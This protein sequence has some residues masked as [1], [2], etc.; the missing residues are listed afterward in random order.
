MQH[1][2][3]LT[4]RRMLKQATA[5]CVMSSLAS[6]TLAEDNLLSAPSARYAGQF[7]IG[8][9]R[10]INRLGYGALKITGEFVWGE[11]ERRKEA[12]EIIRALRQLDVNFVDTADAYG[13]FISEN[14]IAEAV[15]PY[16]DFDGGSL[17]VATK[18]G[19]V[20][21]NPETDPWVEIGHPAYLEQCVRM[22]LRRLKR[23]QLDLWQL[24]RIDPN[25][26]E[27]AQYRAI[28][29]FLEL[30]LIKYA[31]L[32]EVNVE[33]IERARKFFPVATVQNRYNLTYRKSEDV[34][35]YCEKNGIAFIPWWPLDNGKLAQAGGPA[36]L[37]A[38][39][40]GATPAQIAIAWLL[41]KSPVMIPIPGTSRL[42]HLK[43][44]IAAASIRLTNLEMEQLEK[45]TNFTSVRNY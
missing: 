35:R 44:N 30:G 32:S 18:G 2:Q 1:H 41:Q 3:L 24:H 10:K 14:I 7:L 33:Q 31:G 13:P 20:R 45:A 26:P 6:S 40:H 28:S 38:K 23:N 34:L 9:E 5:L 11:P 4:R 27:E 37:I 19:Y 17:F 42:T 21:P 36:D 25:T 15:A 8:G 39:A 12:L 29:R 16:Q 43:E 22:S